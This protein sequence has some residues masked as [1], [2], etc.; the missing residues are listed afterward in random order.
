[1]QIQRGQRGKLE[2]QFDI[3]MPVTITMQ[4]IGSAVYD[5]CCFGIDAADQ[6]S[7]DRYM[8]F[9]N[10]PRTPKSEIT[11]FIDDSRAVYH[12][13]LT[14]LPDSI[15]KLVFTVSIDGNGTMG[16]ISQFEVAISQ[17]G[18]EPIVLQLAGTDFAE[19]KAIISLE[20][21]QKNAWRYS[22]VA[23]GFNGGLGDLLRSY[24]GEEITDTPDAEKENPAAV[25]PEQDFQSAAEQPITQEQSVQQNAVSDTSSQ[26]PLKIHSSIQE[27]AV[28]EQPISHSSSPVVKSA[29]Q[30][31]TT[32]I[33]SEQSSAE[34]PKKVDLL[35]LGNKPVNLKKNEKVELRKPN[36]EILKKVVV[37]LGWDAAK[38]GM[39]IDCDSS[40]FMCQNGKL[41]SNRD[42]IAFYN[43]CHSSGAVLHH[44]DNLTGDGAG[45]DERITID[46][47]KMPPTYDRIV[48]VV[49]IFLSLIKMQHFGKIKNCYM[50]ICDQNGKELCR[51][52]LSENGEYNRKSAMIFGELLKQ[53]DVWV[54]HAI[55]QGTNDHSIDRLAARFK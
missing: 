1:M 44:G 29:I 37:G 11:H 8:V 52:T 55:G 42:I 48:I 25:L 15:Q 2:G 41:C 40:V 47:T 34:P 33:V 10:Q 54:F 45:D 13:N 24:G 46:L 38:A 22:A 21:Y 35:K 50:R 32:P 28:S 18:C 3:N 30:Q 31:N 12:A 16:Q 17:E 9:Y 51:Y 27:Q 4:T 19:E 53:D 7:D 6:L 20:V 14:Q 49:N 43:K 23:R 26:Q 5:Y 36:D 39:S